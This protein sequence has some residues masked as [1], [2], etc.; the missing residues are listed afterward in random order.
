MKHLL[1]PFL[2]L[3]TLPFGRSARAEDC[4]DSPPADPAQR[5]T[6][7][8][9]WFTDAEEAER[10][11][12][13]VAAVRAYQCSMRMVPHAFTAYNLAKVAEQTGDLELAVDSYHHY[14]ALK[15]NAEDA[16]EVQAHVAVLEQRIAELRAQD[17]APPA[18][19]ALKA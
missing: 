16:G 7:A 6:L 10:R 2:A 13:E 3:L 9:R 14:L 1:F 19:I 15:T 17:N 12:D 5:R 4:P 18:P 11:Q 8:K